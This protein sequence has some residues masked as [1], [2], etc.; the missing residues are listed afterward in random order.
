MDGQVDGATVTAIDFSWC[1]HNTCTK[2]NLFRYGRHWV[3]A[4]VPGMI[5]VEKIRLRV[6]VSSESGTHLGSY[7]VVQP[8]G[9]GLRS[10]FSGGRE[11]DG[12]DMWISMRENGGCARGGGSLMSILYSWPRYIGHWTNRS[13]GPC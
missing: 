11:K 9:R 8:R 12:E 10:G 1:L 3:T 13:L 4:N 6:I 5:A 7:C 2:S